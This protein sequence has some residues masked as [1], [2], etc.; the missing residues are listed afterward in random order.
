MEEEHEA[1]CH[2]C[3]CEAQKADTNER[4]VKSQI[5]EEEDLD[6]IVASLNDWD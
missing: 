5:I 4:E 2:C 1:S 3:D 6:A